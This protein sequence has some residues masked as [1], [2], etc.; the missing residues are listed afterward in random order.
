MD[1]E[2]RL[3]FDF[4]PITVIIIG[5]V[6]L[7]FII[8]LIRHQRR[9]IRLNQE[10][11]KAEVLTLENERRRIAADLHDEIGPTLSSIKLMLSGI[12]TTDPRDE[13]TVKKINHH[14]DQTIRR[15]REIS[16][17]LMPRIL[18]KR[19]LADALKMLID[20]ISR[21]HP[22]L[23]I[24]LDCTLQKLPDEQQSLHIYRM[25]Q[26]IT[27]NTIKHAQ[28]NS[29]SIQLFST[30]N[31]LRLITRDDGKGFQLV[32]ESKKASGLGLRNLMSRS[33]IMKGNINITSSPQKGTTI[34][35]NIPLA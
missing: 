16:N 29:L 15:L 1:A 7:Y 12:Q 3:E 22:S 35:L 26:E 6:V 11:V 4:L 13:E 2:T 33:E 34:Q 14:I 31:Q 5:V 30:D 17:N 8:S 9:N 25:I 21:I 27:H 19:G 10:K 24:T 20:E 32:E 23:K 18:E 28:A